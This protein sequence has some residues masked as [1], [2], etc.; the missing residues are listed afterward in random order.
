V[1]LLFFLHFAS[2]AGVWERG[3]EVRR[4]LRPARAKFAA[5]VGGSGHAVEGSGQHPGA[6]VIQ[7]GSGQ[8]PGAVQEARSALP[9]DDAA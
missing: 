1:L 8:H 9:A 6:A 4:V 7:K 3:H 5:A 2:L